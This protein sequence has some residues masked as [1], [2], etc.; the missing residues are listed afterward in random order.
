MLIRLWEDCDFLGVTEGKKKERLYKM[1]YYFATFQ[2]TSSLY[3]FYQAKEDS[4]SL[5]K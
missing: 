2:E 4:F 3:E 1:S 5:V